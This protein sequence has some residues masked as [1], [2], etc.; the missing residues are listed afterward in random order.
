[1][2]ITL[3]TLAG[4][5]LVRPDRGAALVSREDGGHLI[6]NPP[7]QVWDR[8]AL[9]PAELYAWSALVAAAAR[10]ML[11]TLPQLAG[12]CIN[13]WDAGNWS[14]NTA[15]EPVGTKRG[16]DHRQTHLHLLGRS[17]DARSPSWQWG[18]APRFPAFRD[19]HAWAA[20]HEP[21]TD[22]EC[23]R[24]VETLLAHRVV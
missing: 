6:V 21:L 13:Y 12:G 11:E 22:E 15:A 10:A 24:I 2:G 5:T 8:T 7:R 18:E 19:R 4:G 23:R 14:V 1:M 9:E 20:A 16:I 3:L 17:L